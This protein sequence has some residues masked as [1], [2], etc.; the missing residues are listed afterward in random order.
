MTVK[1]CNARLHLQRT[2]QDAVEV[3]AIHRDV[4]VQISV[5]LFRQDDF[6]QNAGKAI[7]TVPRPPECQTSLLLP[8]PAFETVEE[9][10]YELTVEFFT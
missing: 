4:A 8:A 7:Q 9:M 6:A 10:V 3:C 1:H 2:I 5:T